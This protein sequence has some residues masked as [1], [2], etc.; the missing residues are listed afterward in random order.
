MHCTSTVLSGLNGTSKK[1]FTAELY[2]RKQYSGVHRHLPP[3]LSLQ[4]DGPVTKKYNGGQMTE[5][6]HRGLER[7]YLAAPINQFF[8]PSLSIESGRATIHM[9][10]R[11]DFHHTAGAMHGSVYFKA[12]DDAA[13]FASHTIE[14]EHF[15]LTVDFRIDFTRPF[16]NG[17][18]IARGVVQHIGKTDILARADLYDL[19]DKLCV[20]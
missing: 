2:P 9:T 13:Y 3:I 6:H 5:N 17:R 7:I 16:R 18:I 1:L 8:Q 12:L 20:K 15:L 14:R 4:T 19:K 11:S 10:V